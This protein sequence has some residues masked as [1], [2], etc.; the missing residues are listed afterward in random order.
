MRCKICGNESLPFG[1]A[2]VLSR[3]D[4]SYF[5][6][7]SCHFIQTEEPYWLNDAYS[8]AISSQDVGIMLRNRHNAR[9]TSAVISL[10][11]PDATRFL[12]YG[13]GHGLLVRMMRDR[14]FNFLWSDR[15]ANNI[16]ARGFEHQEGLRYD[17]TTAYEVFEHLVNPIEDIAHL[18][19]LTDDLLVTTIV[20]PEPAPALP[21]WW[22]YSVNSGQHISLY[23]AKSLEWIAAYFG[24]HLLSNGEF[25]LF[26]REPRK[27]FLFKL[28]I[29]AKAALLVNRL[30][31]RKSLIPADHQRTQ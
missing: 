8:E 30:M 7:A 6:C 26:T 15:Y 13:G 31:K 4:V 9:A 28:A 2:R 20:V 19:E 29:N 11:Y 17:L 25:H 22:Y 16:F 23:S 3:Y 14:G 1:T 27:G 18:F 12:D 10:L 24:R 5:R 21:D